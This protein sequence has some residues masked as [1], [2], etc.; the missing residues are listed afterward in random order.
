MSNDTIKMLD[1]LKDITDFKMYAHDGFFIFEGAGVKWH[2]HF[3]NT[4]EAI[5]EAGITILMAARKNAP[6]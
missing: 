3:Y 1:K 6:Y 2:G 5:F 4:E